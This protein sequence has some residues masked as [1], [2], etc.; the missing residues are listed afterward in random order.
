MATDVSRPIADRTAI[1]VQEGLPPTGF[2]F[3]SFNNSYKFAPPIFDI[4]MQLLR[5]VDGSVLWLSNANESAVNNLRREAQTREVDGERIVFTRRVERN[6]D[7]LARCRLADLFLDTLPFGAHSTACDALWAGVPLLTCRGTTFSG[8]VAESLLNAVGFAELV[9]DTMESY[10][11]LALQLARDPALL[12]SLKE[13]LAR[14]RKTYP[15]F[16]TE[17]FTRHLEAGYIAMW[18]RYQRGEPPA[19]IGVAPIDA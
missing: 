3:C 2:V 7:H 12:A 10:E 13:K 11:A 8:R 19:S 14:N 16:N 17:R 18:E 6:E 4:W 9:T 15:L 5:E 1:R